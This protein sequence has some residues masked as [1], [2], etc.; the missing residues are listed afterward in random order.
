M[1]LRILLFAVALLYTSLAV[2][3][4]SRDTIRLANASF[5]GEPHAG[6]EDGAGIRYWTDCG[7]FNFK[8]E[9][10][11]DIHSAHTHYFDHR[12]APSHG[13]TYV[14]LVS[15]DNASFESLSQ[16]L[17][18]VLE[19]GKCYEM[20]V[21][22]MRAPRYVSP[23]GE[24]EGLGVPLNVASSKKSNYNTPIILYLQASTGVCGSD[25]LL[26]SSGYVKNTDWKTY[27]LAFEPKRRYKFITLEASYK[28]PTFK[29]YNGN[30]LMDNLRPI[31]EVACPDEEEEVIVASVETPVV[32]P[33][34]RRKTKTPKPPV[35][36]KPVE[37]AKAPEP[38][39]KILD[40]DRKKLRTNQRIE[41]K[42]LY[43][44]ADTSK[45]GEGS[46]EVLDELYDFLRANDDI[47]IEIGGHTNGVPEP[48]YCDKLSSMRA[49][50]VAAYLV[51]R[52][53]SP[54][55]L[56]YRGYGKRRPVAS[57]ATPAG[58][59]KNQRVEITI[60]SMNG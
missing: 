38:K 51:Q 45:I 18:Q 25:E 19:P 46:A 31:I 54:N 3:G 33:H 50:A 29:P 7:K 58:R 42:N 41:I 10:P 23:Y 39:E 21:D 52:G 49:K 36:Q 55:R 34:K 15:R 16:S 22:L 28:R 37:I 8:Y 44:E 43:F 13:S 2:Q 1:T 4:Q 60:T 35:V 17:S 5:D 48:S 57:N 6:G 30:I 12:G 27:T 56:T 40:L 11:P 59:L 47:T 24:N 32:P 26:A 53:V 20:Q 9:T 14:G